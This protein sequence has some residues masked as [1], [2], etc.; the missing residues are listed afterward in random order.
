M[1]VLLEHHLATG[2]VIR[3]GQGDI[4]SQSTEA[5][6]NAANEHLEHGGGV[7]G[8]IVRR[9]GESIQAESRQWVREHGI[10]ATGTAAITGAGILDA[11]FVIHAVGPVWGQGNDQTLLANAVES[12]LA[13]ADE[14]KIKSISI[15]GISSG[16]FGGPKDICAAII[17]QAS[18]EYC[19]HHPQSTLKE[20]YF[21]N[22]DDQT[23]AAFVKA[24]RELFQTDDD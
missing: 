20:I 14:N 9:G 18:L 1:K 12:A 13:L 2:Q 15:P 17:L 3:I 24:A 10:V 6:V 22:I 7:A 8:A 16:I 23:V 11:R 4:T 5:I 21:C 19:A